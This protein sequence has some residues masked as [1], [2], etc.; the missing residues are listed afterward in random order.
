MTRIRLTVDYTPRLADY[1]AHVVTKRDAMEFDT[2]MVVEG[3]SP[4]G[5]LIDFAED[6]VYEVVDE[7]ED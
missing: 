1:P 3:V 7:G 4:E 2:Q 6:I 5:A